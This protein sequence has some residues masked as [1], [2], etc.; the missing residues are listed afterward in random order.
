MTYIK[1]EESKIE[2]IPS[3]LDMAP[4]DF[5]FTRSFSRLLDFSRYHGTS[6][7][8][9]LDPAAG[10]DPTEIANMYL[11]EPLIGIAICLLWIFIGVRF[12]RSPDGRRKED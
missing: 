8:A 5:V 6:E 9:P 4:G 1:N 3:G 2:T 12:H 7:I 10:P 11:T